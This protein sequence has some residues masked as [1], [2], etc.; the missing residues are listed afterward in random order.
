MGDMFKQV[1]L[2]LLGVM[3]FIFIVGMWVQ[4][5]SQLNP[6][7]VPGATTAPSKIVSVNGR[8]VKV[9]VADT[10]EKRQKGLSGR[11]SLPENTGMLFVFNPQDVKPVFWMKDTLIALDIIWINDNKVV[12]V[13]VNVQPPKEGTPES[14][15]VRYT[16]S[17]P[18]DYVLEVPANYT[19]IHS[20]QVG[21]PVDLS[22]I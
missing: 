15:L 13:D 11:T 8:E 9:E 3:A 16:P 18:I 20:T 10:D 5:N 17:M 6:L 4:K 14:A 1:G 19:I 22:K 21:D 7:S 12:K 2:P